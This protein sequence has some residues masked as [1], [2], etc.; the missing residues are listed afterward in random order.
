LWLS[1]FLARFILSHQSDIFLGNT[2]GQSGTKGA[3]EKPVAPASLAKVSSTT[4]ATP[5]RGGR[6]PRDPYAGGLD[7]YATSPSQGRQIESED[8]IIKVREGDRDA[9]LE[10]DPLMVLLKSLLS[11]QP[12]LRNS[13]EWWD[14]FQKEKTIPLGTANNSW[15]N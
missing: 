12:I 1:A 13:L 5:V 8:D 11:F 7:P 15:G 14:V 3:H 2:M 6:G 10:D 9:G 4:P